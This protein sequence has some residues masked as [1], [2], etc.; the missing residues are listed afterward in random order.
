MLVIPSPVAILKDAKNPEPAKLF[1]DFLLSKEG[2]EFVAA[3]YTLPIR[4][5]VEPRLDMGLVHPDEA[6]ARAM[7]LDYDAL[8][9]HKAAYI[10]K[11]TKIIQGG[12]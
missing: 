12:N 4:E 6:K 8:A 9:D 3:A 11:F 5:D 10:E 2:Q 7:T 1:V